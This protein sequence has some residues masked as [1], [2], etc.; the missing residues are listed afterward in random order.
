MLWVSKDDL[1]ILII[2]LVSNL[3]T[4]IIFGKSPDTTVGIIKQ[5][6]LPRRIQLCIYL[7]PMICK[8]WIL[9]FLENFSFWPLIFTKTI[10][11]KLCYK[12]WKCTHVTWK[13]CLLGLLFNYKSNLSTL[14]GLQ[15]RVEI[16]ENLISVPPAY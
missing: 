7:I 8:G 16:I 5:L 10:N 3:R 2:R 12:H 13:L 4:I 9:K 11:V 14:H 1:V 6:H 15:N